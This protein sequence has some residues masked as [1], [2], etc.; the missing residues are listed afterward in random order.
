MA[1]LRYFSDGIVRLRKQVSDIPI[2]QLGNGQT[3]TW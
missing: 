2:G 1:E 3:R